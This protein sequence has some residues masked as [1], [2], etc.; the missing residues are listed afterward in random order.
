MNNFLS[1]EPGIVVIGAGEAGLRA[2]M[3]LRDRGHEGSI[4]VVGEE[5]HAPYERPPLSKALLHTDSVAPP[6]ISG[7]GDIDSKGVRLLSG[8][9]AIAIDPAARSVALSDG[10]SL[11]Y[12][13]LLIAAGAQARPLDVEGGHLARTLRRLDDAISL[14]T[15][16]AR[17]KTLVV[18][19]G[20]FIGLELA[21]AARKRGLSVTVAEA[22]PRILG[23]ATPESVAAVV[24]NW[25]GQAGVE[26]RTGKT[27]S[28]ISARPPGRL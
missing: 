18:I 5:P 24:A 15:N 27:L 16:I 17:C 6:A 23:R 2:A 3:T 7:A 19:G 26:I 12:S 22:A 10:R 20:G 8:L 25:H 11:P 28:R 4:T 1:H 13:R 21:A 14:R 9:E